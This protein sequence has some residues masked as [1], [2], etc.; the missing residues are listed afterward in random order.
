MLPNSIK[1]YTNMQMK[2]PYSLPEC[3]VVELSLE[4]LVCI[5]VS[6]YDK[7]QEEDV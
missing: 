2:E 6:Q 3:R 5:T 7:W 4:S 1:S